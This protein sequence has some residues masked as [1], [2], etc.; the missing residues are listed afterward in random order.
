[1]TV[2]RIIIIAIDDAQHCKTSC[3]AVLITEI[4]MLETRSQVQY[5]LKW[6]VA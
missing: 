3:T 5:L 1:M 6:L 2:N 4:D